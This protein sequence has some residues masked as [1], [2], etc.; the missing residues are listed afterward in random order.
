MQEGLQ[1]A[2]GDLIAI[3]DADFVP[4]EDFLLQTVPYLT[5]PGVGMVQT[6]WGH[7]N[8]DY[9]ALTEVQAISLDAHF[10][11]EHTARSRF[12]EIF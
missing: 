2:T 1:Q 10:I 9:S 4:P 8:R 6:L 7:L 11:L 12:R 3:F 5:D